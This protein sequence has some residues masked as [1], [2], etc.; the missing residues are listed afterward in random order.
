MFFNSSKFK[1]LEAGTNLAWM[2]QKINSQNIAN[3]ETPG[4]KSKSLSF[5]GVMREAENKR[6]GTSG[7]GRIDVKINTSDEVSKRADGNNV[8]AETEYISMYKAYV[9]YSMLLNKVN[10]E[11]DKYNYVLNS[12]M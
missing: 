7:I 9:K 12:N 11:F 8:D 1:T 5:E 6:S 10:S 3:I 4:Y 2:Q